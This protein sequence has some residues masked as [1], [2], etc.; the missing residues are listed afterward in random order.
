MNWYGITLDKEKATYFKLF[1]RKE[2]IYFEPSE[3]Y[4]NIHIEFKTDKSVEEILLGFVDYLCGIIDQMCE[5]V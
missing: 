5:E 2:E 1:L 4:S 3:C